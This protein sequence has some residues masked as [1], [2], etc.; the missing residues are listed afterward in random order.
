MNTTTTVPIGTV[1]MLAEL[2]I[3]FPK[4]WKRPLCEFGKDY[5]EVEGVWT[6]E[7]T[8]HVMPDGDP[9]FSHLADQWHD[10]ADRDDAAYDGAVH[11]GFIA[12]LKA[13]G[14]CVERHDGITYHLVPDRP[15]EA[16]A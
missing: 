3:T 2:S 5:A 11:T 7:D 10:D 8:G 16:T 6:G 14:W 15:P 12:W 4:L 9:I 1:A 13:R